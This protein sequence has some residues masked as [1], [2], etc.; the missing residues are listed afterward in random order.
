[1]SKAEEVKNKL[2]VVDVIGEYISLKSAGSNFKALCPFHNEK[3]PSMMISPEKQIWHCFGCGKGGDLISF[4]MEIEGLDFIEALKILGNKAGVIIDDGNFSQN[5]K[6]NKIL[7]ILDLSRKYYHFV[8]KSKKESNKSINDINNYL[9]KRGLDDTAIDFWQIGYSL[10]SYDDIINFLKSKGFSDVEIFEAGIS[11]K[12]NKGRYLNRFRNRIMFPINDSNGRTIAFTA[13]INP[14]DENADKSLGKY[15][16][17]P[18][19]IA[20]NKSSVLFALDRAKMEIKKKEFLILVEGQMDAISAHNAG[21]KNTCAVSGTSLTLQQLKLI[22]RYTSNIVLAFDQDL[23]GETATDRGIDEALKLGFSIK[24][25]SLEKGRDPDDIIRENPGKFKEA[26][27]KSR[28]VIEYYI[29]REIENNNLKDPSKRNLAIN[30]ILR[31]VNNLY[32]K[33]EQDFWVKELSQKTGI[34]EVFLRED[35]QKISEKKEANFNREKEEEKDPTREDKDEE[36]PLSREDMIMENLLSILF[37]SE[38]NYEY[39]F[40]NLSDEYI[41]GR[42]KDFY[43]NLIIAHNKID[44]LSFKEIKL[45][46]EKVNRSDLS[47]LFDKILMISDFKWSEISSED[48]FVKNEII[49]NIVDIKKF[50]IKERIKKENLLLIEAEKSNDVDRVNSSMKKIKKL[51]DDLNKLK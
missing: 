1:M 12:N 24:I 42:Y 48:P 49:K 33:V 25:A 3:T 26:I 29:S 11:Y 36:G 2:D 7:Q 20:Y 17:S 46:F 8:L 50:F 38:D 39:V 19:S 4:V 37:K 10:N 23:G 45:Y 6:K 13:R 15:I 14:L 32:N 5:N 40:N 31:V 41:L 27:E 28:A 21:F 51:N 44:K 18:Q 47:S 35:L 9:K 43:S 22:K 30:R 34:D 16:N